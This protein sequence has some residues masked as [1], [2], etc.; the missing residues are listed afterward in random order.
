MEG[1]LQHGRSVHA[2]V[3]GA[4][5][6]GS[7]SARSSARGGA[8]PAALHDARGFGAVS[9]RGAQAAAASTRCSSIR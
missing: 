1:W 5:A 6:P 4:A 8:Q 7:V 2:S 3:V 9:R